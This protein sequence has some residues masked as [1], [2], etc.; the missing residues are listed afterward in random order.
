MEI[1]ITVKIRNAVDKAG[2]RAVRN[3]TGISAWGRCSRTGCSSVGS[4]AG[5]ARLTL[6]RRPPADTRC[7]RHEREGMGVERMTWLTQLGGCAAC[8][9]LRAV[10]QAREREDASL[11]HPSRSRRCDDEDR[12]R[13][14]HRCSSRPRCATLGG[15][16]V[17]QSDLPIGGDA[18]AS[19]DPRAAQSQRLSGDCSRM[20]AVLS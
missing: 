17:G 9:A 7:G 5:A 4:A 16:S 6:S 15:G 1:E 14:L 2:Q 18:A 19:W 10:D 3:S 20:R 13:G 12:V 8:R 11:F